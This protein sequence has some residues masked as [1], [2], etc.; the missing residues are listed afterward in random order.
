MN[1]STLGIM[2]PGHQRELTLHVQPRE[3]QT[4]CAQVVPTA[5]DKEIDKLL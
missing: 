2:W 4:P 5:S 1:N 3:A